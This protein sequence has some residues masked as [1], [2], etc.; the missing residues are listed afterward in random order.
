MAKK[1]KNEKALL[2]KALEML[3]SE[4]RISGSRSGVPRRVLAV[5]RRREAVSERTVGILIPHS[6]DT[7]NAPTQQ[8]LRELSSLVAPDGITF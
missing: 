8:C 1:L 3:A 2:R 5:G 6:F 4:G 7:L